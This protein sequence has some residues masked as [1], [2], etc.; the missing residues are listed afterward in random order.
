MSL[1]EKANKVLQQTEGRLGQL[2]GE[3]VNE[4]RY[5]EAVALTVLTKAVAELI[6]VPSVEATERPEKETSV[7]PASSSTIKPRRRKSRKSKSTKSGYPKFVTQ[8]DSLIKIGWSKKSKGE[9]QHKAPWHVVL[10]VARSATKAKVN[11]SL[12]TFDDFTPLIDQD[13]NEVPD[14][15]VYLALAW[16]R[17]AGL[18][19]QDGRNGYKIDGSRLTDAALDKKRNLLAVT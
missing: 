11:G 16:F 18:V 14:Y 13:G 7:K 2:V 6:R 19:D 17:D 1:I 9:Y 8:G 12:V 3:A 10:Q 4:G 15:Q 5:D